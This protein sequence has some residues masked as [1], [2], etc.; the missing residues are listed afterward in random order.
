[1][2]ELSKH[3]ILH[4]TDFLR[5][6]PVFINQSLLT[7]P[8]D[9]EIALPHMHIH[10]FVELSIVLEGNGIHCTLDDCC[11]CGPGDVFAIN[12]GTPHSYFA[13]EAGQE[14]IV[15][16]V[17]F[18]PTELLEGE[19]GDPDHERYCCG[20]FR[21]NPM[22]AFVQLSPAYVEEAKRL[23]DRM[24]KELLR[25]GLEWQVSVRL[26]LMDLL[27]MCS[28][29]ITT[30]PKENGNRPVSK[31]RDRQITMTVMRTVLEH[32]HEPDMTLAGIA[33][34]LFL[35]K[36]HL[37]YI[38]S[39]VT[40]MKF[41]DYVGNVRLEQACRLLRETDSNNEKICHAC[42]FRDVPSFYRFFQTH[43]GMTPLSYRKQ[44]QK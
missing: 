9:P 5:D 28:R 21:E 40:G 38:F 8:F 22:T 32:Y 17:I 4:K 30:M 16:N 39:Q 2:T 35:S 33:D 7:T 19:L 10:D 36:S 11:A 34:T 13:G 23:V 14:L 20:L 25:R 3:G 31:L 44:N 26:H 27:I 12:L 43:M 18:D 6:Q 42:G 15:Q 41:S 29:R 24:E 1:M 37:S